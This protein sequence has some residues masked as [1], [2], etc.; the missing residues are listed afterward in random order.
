M[1]NDIKSLIEESVSKLEKK[2]FKIFF[3]VMDTKG[4]TIASVTNIYEH[5]KVLRELGYDAQ[6]LHE[7]NDYTPIA[8]SLGEG[9]SDIPHVSIESQQLKVNTHDFIIIPEIFAN[10]MEQTAKLPS[11]RI[12]FVQSYDYI[13]EMLVPG[14]SWTDYGIRDVI[15]TSE[16]QKEYVENLFSKRIKAE[17]IPV[18]IPKYFKPS[19]KPKKPII[20]IYTRDQRDLVKIYKAFYLRF[21]HLKWVSFRDMRGLPRETFAKSLAESCLAVWVDRVSSFGTFPLEAIKSDVPVL[22]LVPDMVPE[23]MSDKNGLWTHDPVMIADL[24][25]N[26]FQA[27]LEDSE[28]QELYEEMT[29]LKES[30]SCEEQKEKITE[31]YGKIIQERIEELKSNLPVENVELTNNIE[32]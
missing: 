31:I 1:E 23:W 27:W 9:Y 29:K 2:D 13:F 8:E 4:N 19:D 7:K 18:S 25:A 10:V 14:K 26:Y 15:T 17:V 30:Y 3:F 16:K 11:K 20:S 32:Q 12:V 22:G 21:P 6:I 24:I 28:P 5:A